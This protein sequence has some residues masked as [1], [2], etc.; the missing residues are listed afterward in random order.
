MPLQKRQRT[1]PRER[2]EPP[3]PL[4]T[5]KKSQRVLAGRTEP[6]EELPGNSMRTTTQEEK[7]EAVASS[8]KVMV[9]VS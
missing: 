7:A 5:K 9:D 3:A 6:E 4:I 8:A 2:C 1:A